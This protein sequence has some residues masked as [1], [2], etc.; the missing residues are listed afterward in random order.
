LTGK[1]Q[2]EDLRVGLKFEHKF[3]AKNVDLSSSY[4]NRVEFVAIVCVA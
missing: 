2:F 3:A 4:S 1:A